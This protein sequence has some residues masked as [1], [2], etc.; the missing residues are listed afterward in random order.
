M[1]EYFDVLKEELEKRDVLNGLLGIDNKLFVDPTRLTLA[2][3]PEFEGGRSEIEVYF[4]DVTR[5][6]RLARSPGGIA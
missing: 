3:T 4:G 1:H 5:L 6:W 2:K